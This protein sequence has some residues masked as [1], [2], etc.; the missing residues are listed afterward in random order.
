[1]SPVDETTAA[2]DGRVRR[3][4]LARGAVAGVGAWL[5]GYL[6]AYVWKARAVSEALEGVGFVSR[7]LGGE[8]IPAWK[9]VTWL[10]LNAHF[11]ATR[12]PTVTGGTRTTNVV[13]GEGGST[14]LLALPPLLLLVAGAV[15]AYGRPGGLAA[16]AALALGYLP[17][18]AMAA[19]VTTHAIGDTWAAISADP[20]TAILLA[21]VVYPAAF[22]A[23]GGVVVGAVE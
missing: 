4:T 11:V 9:G 15:A 17:L 16:G 8:A 3:G 21:G 13:T 20:V 5:L 23:V 6:L 18:S 2:S 12:F 10:F 22:G 7:L 14:L 1:M 19:F